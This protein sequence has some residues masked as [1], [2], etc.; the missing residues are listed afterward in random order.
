MKEITF[1]RARGLKF[2]RISNELRSLE[3]LELKTHERMNMHVVIIWGLRVS[4]SMESDI[5]SGDETLT[6]STY[7]NFKRERPY[8]AVPPPT[9]TIIP[10]RAN[11]LEYHSSTSSSR[12][13]DGSYYPRMDNRRPRISSYSP[14]SRS[15]TTRTPHRPQRPKKV[16]KLIWVK[17]GSTVGSQAVLPQTVKKSNPERQISRDL[18]Y[19]LDTSGMLSG[20]MTGDK[21]KLSNYNKSSKVLVAFGNDSKRRKNLRK[22]ERI[23]TSCYKECLILSPKFKFVDEDLATEDEVCPMAQKL[24]QCQLQNIQQSRLRH[25]VEDHQCDLEQVQESTY[26]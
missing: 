24:G 18:C 17:K 22:K 20:S 11:N 7:E 13:T 8:K 1:S 25:K 5:S 14:S 16:V 26:E 6:D 2:F 9:G 10:P 3:G 19:H 4:N 15:S 12:S 21:D 23:K